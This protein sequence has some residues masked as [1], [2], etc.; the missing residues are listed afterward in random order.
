MA[1]RRWGTTSMGR[2]PAD[3]TARSR[4]LVAA[5]LAFHDGRRR[6]AR[7]TTRELRLNDGPFTV[8]VAGRRPRVAA[9]APAAADASRAIDATI[10]ARAPRPQDR[11]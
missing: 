7:P 8:H 10:A 5:M 9:G 4:W 1:L 3:V 2:L 6:A 11:G